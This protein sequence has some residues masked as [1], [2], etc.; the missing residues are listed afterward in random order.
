MQKVFAT[1]EPVSLTIEIGAGSVSIQ[2]T[3]TA[4]TIV[5]V[6]GPRADDVVV[7]QRG[8]EIVV[9][10]READRGWGF[11]GGRGPL[12]VVVTAPAGSNLVAQIA[13]ARLTADGRLGTARVRSGSGEIWI[14]EIAGDGAI[15]SG[16][17][18]L[19]VRAA[20]GDL[21]LKAGSGDIAIGHAGSGLEANLGSGSIEVGFVG[22]RAT[23][24]SGSGDMRVGE[25]ASDI[26]ATTASGDV[27]IELV[28]RG[29]INA[30]TASGDVRVGVGAGIPVWTDIR[31][32]SG[33]IRSDLRGAGQPQAGQDHI[34]IRVTTSSGDVT[35]REEPVAA[36]AA[37]DPAAVTI[38]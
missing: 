15:E 6:D 11:L 30:T 12:D 26:E 21:R 25:A 3:A 37:A 35:L 38:Q 34:E 36:P 9:L 23:L 31:T 14:E 13:S 18:T 27:T 22:G 32:I 24:R 17:G 8:E 20:A 7:E 19:E 33:E 5:R 2:A 4:E 16:S 10:G 29:A 28:R 1:P